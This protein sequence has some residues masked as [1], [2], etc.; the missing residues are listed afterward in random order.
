VRELL[1]ALT[2][3][4]SALEKYISFDSD[5]LLQTVYPLTISDNIGFRGCVPTCQFNNILKRGRIHEQLD[6]LAGDRTGSVVIHPLSK[7][8]ETICSQLFPY[9]CFT[10]EFQASRH[11]KK[12]EKVVYLAY[13]SVD[14]QFG[15]NR[16][17]LT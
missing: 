6:F 8:R 12:E 3:G 13:R 9:F 2:E 16:C 14:K 4:R 1:I 15:K 7:A 11:L 17:I 10:D 5:S